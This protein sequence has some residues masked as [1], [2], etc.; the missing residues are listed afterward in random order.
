[1]NACFITDEPA[2]G[3]FQPTGSIHLF[4]KIE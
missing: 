2:V 3:T 4:G 1:V